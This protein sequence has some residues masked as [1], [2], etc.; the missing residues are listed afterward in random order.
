MCPLT[1]VHGPGWCFADH[2]HSNSD[3][4]LT[5]NSNESDLSLDHKV[6]VRSLY[7]RHIS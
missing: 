2:Y 1:H 7:S 4:T 5:T 3:M 6:T